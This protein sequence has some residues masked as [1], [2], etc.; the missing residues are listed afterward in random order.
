[1]S[2]FTE[3]DAKYLDDAVPRPP[4]WGGYRIVPDTVEFWQARAYR[5][6]DRFRYSLDSAQSSG[7]LVE[8]LSP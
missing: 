1:M 5:L 2:R 8:R 7:W 3:F 4:Y 6:H